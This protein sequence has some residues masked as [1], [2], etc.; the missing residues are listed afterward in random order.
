[1]FR[2]GHVHVRCPGNVGLLSCF[3]Q[4]FFPWRSKS[5]KFAGNWVENVR[6][7]ITYRIQKWIIANC[8]LTRKSTA[9]VYGKRSTDKKCVTNAFTATYNEDDAK[10]VTI[11][12]ILADR[13]IHMVFAG[14]LIE[15]K[16]PLIA[17]DVCRI[18]NGLGLMAYLSIC[19][20]GPLIERV[21]K[22]ISDNGLDGKVFCKGN[23]NRKELDSI[24]QTSHFLLMPS[25]SEGWPKSVAEAMW[26]GTLPVV[27]PVSC[28][29]EMLNHGERG[30]LMPP[31]ADQ[32]AG[33]I[34]S[35]IKQPEHYQSMCVKAM[36]W[37]RGYTLESFRKL[38]ESVPKA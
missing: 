15:G 2:T 3:V 30:I 32:I 31:N 6:Q 38:I 20:N 8:F 5:F 23:L 36:E 33:S 16:N 27:S 22:Y 28:I 1:M 18:L 21:N 25:R 37:S 24:Y 11:R 7:P 26:W 14:S 4:L 13:P 19:G 12:T 17:I 34:A 35:L 10:L 9:L 29:P